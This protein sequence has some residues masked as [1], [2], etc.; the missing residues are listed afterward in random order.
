MI[1][2]DCGCGGHKE[3]PT[4]MLQTKEKPMPNSDTSVSGPIDPE[5]IRTALEKAIQRESM[6]KEKATTFIKEV[7]K[8]VNEKAPPG[9]E[10]QVKALKGKVDNPFAVAWASYN[11]AKK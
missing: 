8:K 4:H 3:K 9:R 5:A 2:E 7:I 10:G 6:N 1:D 11:K